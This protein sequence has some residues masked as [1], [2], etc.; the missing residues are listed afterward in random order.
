LLAKNLTSENLN[1]ILKNYRGL[2]REYV[3]KLIDSIA[4]PEKNEYQFEYNG[5]K[6]SLKN[7]FELRIKEEAERIAE[8][9]GLSEE[10]NNQN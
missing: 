2:K 3:E 5:Q 4:H 7:Y 10:K 1:E 6:I 8:E 9:D